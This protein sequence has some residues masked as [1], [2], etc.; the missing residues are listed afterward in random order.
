MGK[1]KEGQ[2]REER[3][4]TGN[5]G[6]VEGERK[7]SEDTTEEAAGRTAFTTSSTPSPLSLCFNLPSS[8]SL[9]L[10][11]KTDRLRGA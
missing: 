3:E 7:G 2:G 10:E 1:E 4:E 5:G 8:F 11:A 6:K 9:S